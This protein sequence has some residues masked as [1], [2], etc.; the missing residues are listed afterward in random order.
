VIIPAISI[1]S[2]YAPFVPVGQ[3]LHFEEIAPGMARAVV[4][5][6]FFDQPNIPA[7][8]QYLPAGWRHETPATSFIVGRLIA[9]SAQRP[10]MMRWWAAL[11]RLMLRIA[12]PVSEYFGLP[13]GRVI[14]IGVEVEI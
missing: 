7:A 5:F 10:S 11:Y 14:E 1:L 3:R 13:A 8:L 2:G 4:T 6:G 12:G 9:I